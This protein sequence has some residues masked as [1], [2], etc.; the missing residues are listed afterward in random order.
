L[1]MVTSLC[2]SLGLCVMRLDGKTPVADRQTLIT[3]FNSE[4]NSDNV[5]LLSTKAGGIGLNLI[6]ASRL[7]LFDSDWNPASDL[8]AMA[9][10]WR[11]G[12]TKPCHIYRLITAGTVE[13][14]ILHRQIKK[15]GLNSLI[16]FSDEPYNTT[17]LDDELKD[18]F[19]L[20]E[21]ECETH[22]MAGCSCDGCGL[23]PDEVDDEPEVSDDEEQSLITSDDSACIGEGPSEN[24]AATD[25]EL[26]SNQRDEV[27]QSY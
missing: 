19:T 17:F 26:S 20:S 27:V 24:P 18:I 23:L 11:D 6:G 10:I 9:R 25:Q 14:K 2:S 12:Q 8:Q 7:I 4:K 22:E 15:T 16:N 1:D 3:K 13:E 21:V 5:F